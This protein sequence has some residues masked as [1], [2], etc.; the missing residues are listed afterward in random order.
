VKK[1][2]ILVAVLV[3]TAALSATSASPTNAPSLGAPAAVTAPAGKVKSRWQPFPGKTDEGSPLLAVGW[4]A[5]RVWLVTP[6]KDVPILRSASPSGGRLTSFA[7][8]RVPVDAGVLV[9]FPIVDGELLV[10]KVDDYGTPGYISAPLLADGQLGPSKAVAYDDLF[11]QAKEATAAKLASVQLL[12]GMRVG[13]RVVWALD[14]T[15]GCS[16]CLRYFLACCS[17]SGAAVDLTRFIE[18]HLGVL[19]LHIGRDTRGRIWLAWLDRRQYPHAARGVARILE[20]D[21]ST[22]E[23]RSDAVAIPRVVADRIDLACAGVCRLVAQTAAGNIVS[24]APGERSPTR[25]ASAWRLKIGSAPA[26]LLAATYQSG[27]LIVAYHGEKGKTQYADATVRDDIRV[28]GGDARGARPRQVAAIPVAYGWPAENAR[29][30]PS[31]PDVHATFVP[32][33]LVAVETF[34]AVPNYGASPLIGAFVPL[35]P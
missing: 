26:W 22:L 16:G 6:Y 23:P 19:F 13:T 9:P 2:V 27:H 29:S 10:R 15:R 1:L 8:T 3:A 12:D 21:P 32:G 28:V 24:W 35:R 18:R 7:Q 17:E 20:L 4:A 30:G 34:Q 5:N 25:V 33:G 11:T 31:D 14:G